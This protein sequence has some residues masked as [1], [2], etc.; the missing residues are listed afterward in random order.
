MEK[1]QH[2]DN[3][4]TGLV[5][6]N[7]KYGTVNCENGQA[8]NIFPEDLNT[9]LHGDTVLVKAL[10]D[11]ERGKITK[12][13]KRAKTRFAGIIEKTGQ[14]TIVN[15]D[16]RKMYTTIT[17]PSAEATD[18]TSGDKVMVEIKDWPA[19]GKPN[20]QIIKHLGKRGGNETEMQSILLDRGFETDFL[21]AV[22]AEAEAAKDRFAE[23]LTNEAK[24]RRDFRGLPTMTID[25]DDAK[26]FDD[27]L[28]FKKLSDDRFEVGVHIADVSYY[29]RPGSEL[30]K[31]AALRGTSVYLVDRTVPMLPEILSNDICSLRPDEDRLAFSAVFEMTADGEIK[32]EWFGRSIIRSSQRFAYEDVQAILDGDQSEYSEALNTLNKLAYR[33]REK[34]IEAGAITFEDAEVK[35]DL[36]ETGRPIGV[37]LRERTDAH[38]LIEDFML[39]ANRQVA[40]FVSQKT[41]QTPHT[42]IYRIHDLPDMEKLAELKTF[43]RPFGFDLKITDEHISQKELNRLLA[44]VEETSQGPII[45]RA[46][47]RAMAKAI[48]STTNIGHWGLGFD[49][50]THFTSPI[51]RYPDLLVHRLLDT[52]LKGQTPK[53]AEMAK[54]ARD[55]IQST[56]REIKAAEAERESVKLKQVEFMAGK[57]GQT[58]TGIISG[59]TKWG[60][61]IEETE[62]KADGMARMSNLGDDYFEL[63]EKNYQIVGKRTGQT[64]RLGDKVTFKL[65]EADPVRRQL[66]Y[67]II[68]KTTGKKKQKAK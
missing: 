6:I 43:L 61:F 21:P 24:S 31:E 19:D 45:H 16:D 38:K 58:F 25:P 48:Y 28:S 17:I 37:T 20:G 33:L 27:A 47:I 40:R 36:D 12:I 67:K 7:G 8:L 4:L 63:D 1:T 32:Q 52:Y 26:D 18:L 41:K 29:V 11:G 15:P 59:V 65:T 46:A 22:L 51:R 42:F 30:D 14:T 55:I 34:K 64:F 57:I 68:N 50:Y 35:F 60:L 39:L 66:D 49:Y 23:S 10:P 9:A 56:D 2:Q 53:Q 62:T 3:E 44:Q 5:R 54:V 13:I